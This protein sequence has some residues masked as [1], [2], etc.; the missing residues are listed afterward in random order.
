M[1][2]TSNTLPQTEIC[3]RVR[4]R[5]RKL[6]SRTLGNLATQPLAKIGSVIGIDLSVEACARDGNVGEARIEQVRVNAGVGAN[7]DALGGKALRAVAGDS[8]AVVEMR[9]LAGVELNLAVIGQAC[10]DAAIGTDRFDDRKVAIR[11]A[12]CFV[13]CCELD[14]LA[15]GE[16]AVDFL[17][18]TH[19][20]QATG[21]VG[22]ELMV[23]LLDR[24]QVCGRVDC[25]YR[26]IAP[27]PI[28]IALLPRV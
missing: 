1:G 7:E 4:C 28:P 6:D 17:I 3:H 25:N 23:R 10:G 2:F 21:I 5:V 16:L 27:A 12:E 19:A 24:E 15:Y 20:G 8:I 18:D 9:M 26:R 11:N 13:G 22:R 14:T